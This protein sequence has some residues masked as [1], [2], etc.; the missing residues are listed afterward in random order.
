MRSDN[1]DAFNAIISLCLSIA[2]TP[3]HSTSMAPRTPADTGLGQHISVS[4]SVNTTSLSGQNEYDRAA[5]SG[6][7]SAVTSAIISSLTR[8][9]ERPVSWLSI[10]A[11]IVGSLFGNLLKPLFLISYSLCPVLFHALPCGCR[12]SLVMIDI[13]RLPWPAFYL[14]SC[15]CRVLM[16]SYPRVISTHLGRY[17]SMETHSSQCTGQWFP[18]G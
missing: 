4:V 16:S 11:R 14:V 5:V 6:Q 12:C 3:A 1:H 13:G 15:P 17:R 7:R 2:S 10:A 9:I 8:P 18:S